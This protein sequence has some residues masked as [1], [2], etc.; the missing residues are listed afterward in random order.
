M[1]RKAAYSSVPV[2]GAPTQNRDQLSL[3][4]KSLSWL[5]WTA[6]AASLATLFLLGLAPSLPRNRYGNGSLDGLSKPGLQTHNE[7]HHHYRHHHSQMPQ[8]L[9]PQGQTH[10]LLPANRPSVNLC[11]L[12]LGATL[13]GYPSPVLTAWGE[14]HNRDGILGGGSHLAKVSSVLRYLQS[15]PAEQ[16]NDTVIMLDAYDIWLQLPMQVLLGRYEELLSSAQSRLEQSLEAKAVDYEGLRQLILFGAGKRC[17]PNLMHTVA[18]YALAESPLPH[19]LYGNDTDT[20]IGHNL[21]Y[22]FR[23]RYLNSGV[24]IGPVKPMR[25]L[26]EE[27]QRLVEKQPDHDPLDDGTGVSDFIYHGSDQSIFA[28]MYGRQELARETLRLKHSPHGTKPRSSQILGANIDNALDPSFTHEKIDL[29]LTDGHNPWEYGIFL[30]YWS[31]VAHQTVNSERDA[32]WLRYSQRNVEKQVPRRALFDCP[33]RIPDGIPNDI[34]I[35]RANTLDTVDWKLQPLYTHLCL[36]RVPVLVHHN[37]DKARRETEWHRMWYHR[38]ASAMLHDLHVS[39]PPEQGT[40]EQAKRR[41]RLSTVGGAWTD[42][43]KH[44]AWSELCP[45]DWEREVLGK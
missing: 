28:A 32:T 29:N 31:D 17:A 9:K 19:D 37:G 8:V 38:N 23:Q 11:K 24:I 43:G 10:L 30:D 34:L 20:V 22:S 1:A 27:A 5:G 44:L 25:H 26:F 41:P 13:L 33:V 36:S 4:R 16:D 6:L 18:C 40:F 21:W 35:S 39:M 42:T 14:E 3:R 15:L 12:V 2:S 45:R 7:Q